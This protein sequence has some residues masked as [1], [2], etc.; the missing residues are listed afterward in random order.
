MLK[1][2]RKFILRGNVIDLAVAVVIGTAFTAIVTAMVKDIITPLIAA[3]IGQYDFSRLFITLNHSKLLYGDFLNAVISFVL[4]AAVVFFLVVQPVNKLVAYTNR[5]QT[6]EEST[7]K[8]CEHCL[9]TIPKLAGVCAFCTK[10]V[11]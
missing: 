8:K 6:P 7:D 11:K 4:I 3:I 2:F 1:D 10:A 5:N 9:S